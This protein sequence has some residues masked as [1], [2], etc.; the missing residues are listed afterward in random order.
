MSL[1]LKAWIVHGLAAV[2]V[3]LLA[4]LAVGWFVRVDIDVAG[5]S[6]SVQRTGR[7]SFPV[8]TPERM[9]VQARPVAEPTVGARPRNVILVIGDGMGLGHL[10]TVSSLVAGPAGGLA[11]EAAPVVGLVRTWAANELVTDSAAAATAMATGFKTHKRMLGTLPDGRQPRTIFD[12]AQARG[13]A[14]GVVTTSGVADATPAGFIAHSPSRYAYA[15]ILRQI[16][17]SDVDVV[18]GGTFERH[19][20]AERQRDYLDLVARAEEAAGARHRVVRS[21]AALAA[22]VDPVVALF[23]P[24]TGSRYAHGPPLAET[25]RAVLTLLGAAPEG[26]LL[27]VE[28]EETDEG[29]HDNSVDRVVD[30]LAEL[31][32]AVVRI[33]DFAAEDGET[34]VIVTADHDTAGM[35]VTDGDFDD[36]IAEVRWLWH[37]HLATWVPLFAFGPGAE[38]FA[39]VLDNTEI[40]THIADLLGLEGVPSVS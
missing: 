29:A 1:R 32:A 28:S 17:E 40:A 34:L 24:R 20:R 18:V 12:A 26:F 33:L 4:L 37:D 23:P 39:G 19:E 8:P 3:A 25:L 10:A 9:A 15:S 31:D 21:G 36:G 22:S 13:M 38:A 6:L 35:A 14:T 27:V 30:G 16:L 11:V 5:M 2:A 7:R